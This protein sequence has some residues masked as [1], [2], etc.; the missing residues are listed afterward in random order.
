MGSFSFNSLNDIPHQY[1]PLN[2]HF[3]CQQYALCCVL[4]VL[5]DRLLFSWFPLP[6]THQITLKLK[7]S[8]AHAISDMKLLRNHRERN[9][10]WLKMW[11]L[12][13]VGVCLRLP[14]LKKTICL[15]YILY[16][17]L[18]RI[19]EQYIPH[20]FSHHLAI[21]RVRNVCM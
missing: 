18:K 4:Y 10:T 21:P 11:Y 12:D 3:S 20:K 17:L 1:Y 13:K 14:M 2:M 5:E 9:K 6:D 16:L 19:K 15:L 7:S 8:F